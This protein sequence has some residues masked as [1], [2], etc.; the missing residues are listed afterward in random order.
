[1]IKCVS[2]HLQ[3]YVANNKTDTAA[4]I[5]AKLSAGLHCVITPGV[6]QLDAALQLTKEG[7]VGVFEADRLVRM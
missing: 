3:V 5:N 4:T 7:Q 6:Y 1:M 2:E